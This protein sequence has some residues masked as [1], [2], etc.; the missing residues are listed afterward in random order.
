MDI[1]PWMP[2][3]GEP[4]IEKPVTFNIDIIGLQSLLLAKNDTAQMP[5]AEQAHFGKC[6]LMPD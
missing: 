2:A 6:S 4:T 5:C 3:Q 1:Q